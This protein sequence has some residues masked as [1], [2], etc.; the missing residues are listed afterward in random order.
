MAKV[1]FPFRVKSGGEYYEAGRVVDVTDLDE[2]ISIGGVPFNDIEA[3][4]PVEQVEPEQQNETEPEQ[5]EPD[6][7]TPRRGR[8]KKND[9]DE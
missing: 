7:D 2:A 3:V 6:T 1:K 8:P 9:M 5:V 4:A